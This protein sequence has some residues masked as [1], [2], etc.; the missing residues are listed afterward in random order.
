[1]HCVDNS[2][3]LLPPNTRPVEAEGN[4]ED[5]ESELD[6]KPNHIAGAHQEE[7]DSDKDGGDDQERLHRSFVPVTYPAPYRTGKTVG[8]VPQ[9]KENANVEWSEVEIAK[10]LRLQVDREETIAGSGDDEGGKAEPNRRDGEHPTDRH[11]ILLFSVLATEAII[12]VNILFILFRAGHEAK[13]KDGEEHLQG[14][15]DDKRT[16]EATCF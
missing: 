12:T 4:H 6:V 5:R 8:T 10:Y 1:V 14:A 9:A 16:H 3:N 11:L 2:D 15:K 13:C 7:R